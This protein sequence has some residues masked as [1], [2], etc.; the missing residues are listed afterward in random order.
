MSQ[1][2]RQHCFNANVI[3][4]S[5]CSVFFRVQMNQLLQNKGILKLLKL[6]TQLLI[7]IFTLNCGND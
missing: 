4:N 3:G 1:L 7:V 2:F 6:K 5:F